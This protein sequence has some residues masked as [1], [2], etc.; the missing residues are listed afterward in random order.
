MPS[1][2]AVLDLAKDA[3]PVRLVGVVPLEQ[4]LE[5][6]ALR[7]VPDLLLPKSVNSPVDV[8]ARDERLELFEAHEVLLVQRAQPID[9]HLEVTDVFLDLLGC[10]GGRPG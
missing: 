9:G 3:L 8:L 1:V 6:E 4:H 7:R 5:A 2:G 10:H